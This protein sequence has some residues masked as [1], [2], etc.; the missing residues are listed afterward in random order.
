M[1]SEF[2]IIIVNDNAVV[3]INSNKRLPD[4]I[5]KVEINIQKKKFSGMVVFDLLVSNG[6]TNRF[7]EVPFLSGSFILKESRRAEHLENSILNVA[8]EYFRKNKEC[9]QNS[10]I[11]RIEKSKIMNEL[12]LTF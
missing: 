7:I 12:E 8:N 10:F 2:K 6:L 11:T 1:K 3:L 5:T 4:V 9:I